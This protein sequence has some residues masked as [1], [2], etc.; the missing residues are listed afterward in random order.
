VRRGAVGVRALY[1]AR[2]YQRRPEGDLDLRPEIFLE[3]F[4]LPL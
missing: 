2:G 3:A 4:L 1:E